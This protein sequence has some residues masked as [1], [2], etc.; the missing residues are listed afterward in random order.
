MN[1]GVSRQKDTFTLRRKTAIIAGLAF[2]LVLVI[3]AHAGWAKEPK[4]N[5][6]DIRKIEGNW[7]RPDGGYV[8][9]IKQVKKDGTLEAA[10]FNPSPINVYEARY[11][12]VNAQILIFIELRDTNYPGSTYQLR[13]N[14]AND[15]L[16]GTYFQA[17]AKQ[18]YHIEFS[19][20]LIASNAKGEKQ[21]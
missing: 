6:A 16:E 15:H 19:R 7:I 4:K 21:K 8:L 13:Y 10:Y 9:E 1:V 14:A 11:R 17:L 3:A 2:F 5:L 20:R 12:I 18:T